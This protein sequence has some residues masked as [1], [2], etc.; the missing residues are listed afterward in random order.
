MLRTEAA[1]ATRR[2]AC[3][4]SGSPASSRSA[5]GRARAEADTGTGGRNEDRDVTARIELR[6]HVAVLECFLISN[7]HVPN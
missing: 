4:S 2:T 7:R 6:G 1:A 3:T 5:L